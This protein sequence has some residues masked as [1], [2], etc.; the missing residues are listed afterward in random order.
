MQ[1]S[2]TAAAA[3]PRKLGYLGHRAAAGSLRSDLYALYSGSIAFTKY[4]ML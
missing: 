3:P 2:P 4:F 1:Y